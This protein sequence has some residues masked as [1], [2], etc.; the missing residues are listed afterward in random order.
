MA[1][2]NP[3]VAA[4]TYVPASAVEATLVEFARLP[5]ETRDRTRMGELAGLVID[6]AR[7]RLQY[8]VVDSTNPA[9]ARRLVP[10][11]AATI[12]RARGALRLESTA[13]ATCAEFDPSAFQP[14]SA[15][16]TTIFVR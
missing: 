4:L 11:T 13:P 12:D 6:L 9:Q 3:A 7:H 8:L 2:S 1:T 16:A 10:F 5:V 15:D 14:L